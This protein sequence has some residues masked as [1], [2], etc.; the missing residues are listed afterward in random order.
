MY[1][2]TNASSLRLKSESDQAPATGPAG[3]DEAPGERLHRLEYI[4]CMLSRWRQLRENEARN[5][6]IWPRGRGKTGGKGK[7]G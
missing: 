7:G 4:R 2:P 6:F 1:L 3:G 5:R